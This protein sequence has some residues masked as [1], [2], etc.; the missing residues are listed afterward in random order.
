MRIDDSLYAV[1]RRCMPIPCV[2]LVV[3]DQ[4]ARILLVE[5]SN[6]PAAGQWWFPGGRVHL[7]ERR[8]EAAA[9][10]LAEECGLEATSIRAVGT[11]DV[12]LPVPGSDTVSHA[13]STVF[14]VLVSSAQ[15]LNLDT[16]ARA[17]E[18]HTREEWTKRT[19]DPFVRKQL[20]SLPRE[21]DD[22]VR[23]G[24]AAGD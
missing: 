14:H 4:A 22:G 11:C 8:D 15:E 1:I 21:S 5:R 3:E 23:G 6:E 9:R 7:G 20:Q 18:W 13:I 17:A 12:I 16:Q 24:A 2:D 10:K 19:L